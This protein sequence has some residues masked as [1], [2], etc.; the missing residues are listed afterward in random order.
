VFEG[1]LILN[2][3]GPILEFRDVTKTFETPEGPVHALEKVTLDI[4]SGEYLAIV[5]PSGSGKTTLLNLA[6][7]LDHPSSGTVFFRG[8]DLSELSWKEMAVLRRHEI[9]FVFQTWNLVQG[10]SA[11]DNVRLP[12]AFARV[13]KQEQI[14]RAGKLLELVGLADRMEH[15]PEEMS[16]GQQQRVAIARAIA[17]NPRLL[18]ADEPTGNLDEE[19]AQNIINLLHQL[20]QS[21]NVTVL[22]ATHDMTLANVADRSVQI[23]EGRLVPEE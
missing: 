11:L 22:C 10:L 3:T 16:G 4:Q 13:P 20:N 15:P 8:Q 21:E 7:S 1:V 12:M 23:I 2:D 17:N 14:A 5:G 19:N 9:G 18:L 6:G